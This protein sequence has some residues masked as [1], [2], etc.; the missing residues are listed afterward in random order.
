MAILAHLQKRAL[1][2][3]CVNGMLRGLL[4]RIWAQ[5]SGEGVGARARRSAVWSVIDFGGSQSL[6]LASNL[7]LTRLL[8]PEAF[9]LMALVSVIMA[10]L[11]LFSD[12]GVGPLIGQSSRGDDRDFLNTAWTVSVF[13]GLLLWLMTLG[14]AMPVAAFYGAPLLAPMLPVAGLTLLIDGF[15]PT[16]V[17]TVHRHLALGRFVLIKLSTQVISLVVMTLL[18]WRFES[19]WALVVG[20]VVGSL[21]TTIAYHL[22]L[23]GIR[24]RFRLDREATGQIFHFGKW[25]F[26]STAAGFLV[27]QGDRAILGAYVSLEAL[28]IY[29]I[30]YFLASIP[31]LLSRSLQQVVLPPLYRM[32]PPADSEEN[33]AAIFR[34]R[35]LIALGM[36]SFAGLLSFL[37]PWLVE[38][39]YDARYA[40]A[41]VMITLFSL[42]VI[43]SI[44]LNTITAALIGVG[45]TR[46]IFIINSATALTQTLILIVGISNYGVVGA[47]IAPGLSMLIAYPLSLF[48]SLKYRL[49]DAVQ[50]IA[51]TLFGFILPMVACLLYKTEI[52]A[53]FLQ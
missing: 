10:G 47:L 13:R 16:A 15:R 1:A 33:R 45:D 7:V 37:G 22:F 38:F 8:F 53:L 11:T 41:G 17:H 34:A 14:L 5:F 31:L 23:P 43:P 6:R 29:N 27:N 2:L 49:F 3:V 12:T 46:A 35:R 51:L 28:G 24:N 52:F 44:S 39:L 42:S 30:G 26:L 19:V 48:Y 32:K 40:S 4:S 36:L 50:D 25:I 20:S 21:L 18:A 9:G